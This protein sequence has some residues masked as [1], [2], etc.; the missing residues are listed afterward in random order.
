MAVVPFYFPR[1]ITLAFEFFFTAPS[2]HG[3]YIAMVYTKTQH[4]IEPL[5]AVNVVSCGVVG[6][7]VISY[8]SRLNNLQTLDRC[9][10]QLRQCSGRG[11]QV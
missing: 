9:A 11:G 2:L 3:V 6:I 1:V 5:I 4:V 7:L 8:H 10:F